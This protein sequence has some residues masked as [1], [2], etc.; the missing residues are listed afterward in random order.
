MS[1]VRD[2]PA[3]AQAYRFPLTRKS[4]TCRALPSR[5]LS[6]AGKLSNPWGGPVRL[7]ATILTFI[8]RRSGNRLDVYTHIHPKFVF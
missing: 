3:P 7:L 8:G 6:A 2:M 1:I 4:V 5:R